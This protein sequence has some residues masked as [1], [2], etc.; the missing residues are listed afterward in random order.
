[1]GV[2]EAGGVR[3]TY[4]DIVS[5][6]DVSDASGDSDDGVAIASSSLD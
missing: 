1:M 3:A 2:D 6:S 5:V 4:V